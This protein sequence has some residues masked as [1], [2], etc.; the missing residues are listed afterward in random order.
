MTFRPDT[1]I[2]TLR[3]AAYRI[4]TDAPEADGTFQWNATTLVVV[5][6]EAGGETGLGYTY[7]TRRWFS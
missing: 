1:T 4:P 2:R 6:I 5:Q 7:A 3:V